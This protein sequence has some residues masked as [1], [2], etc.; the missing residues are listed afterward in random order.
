MFQEDSIPNFPFFLYLLASY[1]GVHITRF[2]NSIE[3]QGF[4]AVFDLKWASSGHSFAATD[5]H[6][7]LLV[8]GL[9]QNTRCVC[10]FSSC[11]F[12]HLENV[13]GVFID[14]ARGGFTLLIVDVI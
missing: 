1:R 7:H 13:D 2:Q 10:G 14:K 3:G 6:G 4:G 11:G 5:S 8:Y 9:G 12:I